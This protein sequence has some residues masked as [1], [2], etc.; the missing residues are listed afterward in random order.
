MMNIIVEVGGGGHQ[1]PGDQQG[2]AQPDH[3]AILYP[4]LL[5]FLQA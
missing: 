4:A 1:D 2:Q 5:I 3:P